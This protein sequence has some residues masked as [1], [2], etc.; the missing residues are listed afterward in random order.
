MLRE[1]KIINAKKK[2][3]YVITEVNPFPVMGARDHTPNLKIV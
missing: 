2:S 3:E 1:V